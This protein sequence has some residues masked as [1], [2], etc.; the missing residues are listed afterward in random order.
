MG[1]IVKASFPRLQRGD[2]LAQGLVA[3]WQFYEG[4]GPTLYD[5]SG[6]GNNG[7]LVNGPSWV[8]GRAGWAL[9]FNGSN[10]S[11]HG[12]TLAGFSASPG[13]TLSFCVNPA[14]AAQQGSYPTFLSETTP[15]LV[16]FLNSGT[17]NLQAQ[18]NST[19]TT[20]ST[21]VTLTANVWQHVALVYD[22]AHAVYYING[23]LTSY[24]LAVSGTV[25][26][27]DFY[28]GNW[29]SITRYFKGLLD[30]MRLY[31]RALSAD[32]VA[33]MYAQTGIP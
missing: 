6:N 7:A 17:L 20:A 5:A 9:S 25:A 28:I 12:A 33:L 8:G 22:G 24:S 32:E 19:N 4:S 2:R 18:I 29:S 14:P 26:L 30:D 21:A 1:A 15:N 11:V 16:A 10:Q 13:A 31:N 27:S 3:A 23:S